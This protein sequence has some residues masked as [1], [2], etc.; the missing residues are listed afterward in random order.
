[1]PTALIESR[2]PTTSAVQPRRHL[3][4][5]ALRSLL[6]SGLCAVALALAGCVSGPPASPTGAGIAAGTK[7]AFNVLYASD[8]VIIGEQLTAWAS[9]AKKAGIGITLQSGTFNHVI[10]V[11][12]D[13][14]SPKTI[15]AIDMIAPKS[16]TRS[17]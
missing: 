9:D 16:V 4:D 3:Q 14:G 6:V 15:N 12:N 7:L 10:T 17:A 8:P 2:V 11:A 5:M 1:M 13:P